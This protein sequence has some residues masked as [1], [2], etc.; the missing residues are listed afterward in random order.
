VESSS[1]RSEIDR[2][3]HRAIELD[4]ITVLQAEVLLNDLSKEKAVT[5]ESKEILASI[6]SRTVEQGQLLRSI[7]MNLRESSS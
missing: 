3:L 5:S 7:R 1:T 4:Q 2:E 6:V